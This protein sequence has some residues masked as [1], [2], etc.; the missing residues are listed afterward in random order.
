MKIKTKVNL[1]SYNYGHYYIF[2][3]IL[4]ITLYL[5]LCYL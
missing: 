1:L 2:I 3:N 5:Y 4:K